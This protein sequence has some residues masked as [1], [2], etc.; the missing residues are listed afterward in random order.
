MSYSYQRV[1][2]FWIAFLHY[3]KRVGKAWAKEIPLGK[4]AAE[5]VRRYPDCCLCNATLLGGFA[6]FAPGHPTPLHHLRHICLLSY[7]LRQFTL[8]FYFSTEGC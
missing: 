2:L 6:S 3:S 8:S 5:L 1:H 7:T 4:G